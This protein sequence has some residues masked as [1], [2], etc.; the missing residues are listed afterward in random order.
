MTS[1]LRGVKR[2]RTGDVHQSPAHGPINGLPTSEGSRTVP[3]VKAETHQPY[4]ESSHPLHQASSSIGHTSENNY[5]V[6][7][8]THYPHPDEAVASARQAYVPIK[9]TPATSITSITPPTK[10]LQLKSPRSSPPP[11]STKSRSNSSKAPTASA[12]RNVSACNRCRLRKNRCD[13]H[14][15]S[16]RQCEKANVKCVGYDPFLNKEVP[17]SYVYHLETRTTYL[18]KLLSEHGIQYLSTQQFALEKHDEIELPPLETAGQVKAPAHRPKDHDVEHKKEDIQPEQSDDKK[19]LDSLMSNI[20]TVYVQGNSDPRYVGTTSGISFA[21]VVFAAV[22]ST[23]A[24]IP[25]ETGATSKNGTTA[26]A[27]SASLRDSAFGLQTRTA[28]QHAPFPDHDLAV[29]LVNLYFEHANPQLPILHRGEFME[30]FDRIY[31]SPDH[32]RTPREAYLLKIVYA[33]GA[34]IVMDSSSKG[35]LT[36]SGSRYS[37]GSQR[38][39]AISNQQYLPEEYH[40]AA[41]EHLENFLQLES[42]SA[43]G[44]A[45]RVDSGL[46][47]LQAVLLL[48]SFALLRPVAPGLWYIVGVA[49][50]LAVDLGLHHEEGD[51]STGPVPLNDTNDNAVDAKEY[52]RRQWY[53]DLRRRL[54]W[55]V[56]SIDRLVSTSVGRPIGITDQVITTGFPSLL[57]D[58]YITRAG[59]IEPPQSGS[60]SAKLVAHHYFRL[61]LLH[62]EIVQVLSF[63][64]AQRAHASKGGVQN[65]F[66]YTKLPSPFL[67]NFESYRQWRDDV[68]RRLV[69]WKDSSPSQEQTGVDFPHLT[70]DL[71]YWQ[72]VITLYQPS[73]SAPPPL[74]DKFPSLDD[75]IA[76][77]HGLRTDD[78]GDEEFVSLKIAEAGQKVLK[79]YRQLHRLH[80]VN[81]TYLATHH[82]FMAGKKLEDC[83]RVVD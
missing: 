65:E 34:G 32:R 57:E 74:V 8:T 75:G 37:K 3:R 63:R 42:L 28:F 56:Y 21:R 71:N 33:I 38:K 51:E 45:D 11:S 81:Y 50:R 4:P 77:A 19:S 58:K 60:P 22:K 30:L 27:G 66:M 13:Q 69:E 16:C 49:T 61:R 46:E 80:F 53:R 73:L 48:A 59:F 43:G 24:R 47:E 1:S 76:S 10:L 12:F 82:L 9:T 26:L 54:W 70:F 35:S 15:P 44:H 79:L 68:D 18:E 2:P 39:G 20:G 14:L 7:Y 40:A 72:T 52:G 83:T 78:H 67:I 17:R 25:S 31:S 36:S 55:C 23:M 6:P 62:S 29:K 41:I 5:P 64:N